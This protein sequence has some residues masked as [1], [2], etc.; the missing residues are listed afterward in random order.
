MAEFDLDILFVSFSDPK[1]D[2][3]T[4]NLVKLIAGKQ[5]KKV[6]LMAIGKEEDKRHYRAL[7]IQFFPIEESK[8]SKM[9][10][11]WNKFRT[12]A[13]M[14]YRLIRS[15]DYFACDLWSL[16]VAREMFRKA[17]MNDRYPHR[18]FYDSREIYSALGPISGK[19]IKQSIITEAEKVN[20]KDV[21]IMITSGVMDTD[22]LKDHFG[23]R[24]TP[25]YEIYN[26]PSFKSPLP[27][28]ILRDKLQL[29]QEH[30]VFIY[31]GV[32]LPGR[33]LKQAIDAV[34]LVDKAHLFIVGEGPYYSEIKEYADSKNIGNK[35]VFT[36]PVHYNRLHE[37]TCSAD[38]GLA[39]FEPVSKSYELSLPNKLFEYCMAGIPSLITD[40]PQMADIL[41]KDKIGIAVDRK[42]DVDEIADKMA[43]L[44]HLYNRDEFI[45]ATERASRRYSYEAQKKDILEIFR[46]D[47][48]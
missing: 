11:R 15:L 32:I 12:Q 23:N 46:E 41:K 29:T 17:Q 42:L 45:K 27:S 33:G 24:S 36:G 21:D 6:G 3:R 5:N 37:V 20:V 31:Q 16:P 25:Y 19:G 14:Y 35:V 34:A 18:L 30:S 43:Y 7:S 48:F 8:S 26:Y 28:N 9:T 10:L 1:K 47:D 22:Y 44:H 40:L 13:K 38:V 4:Y 39:L 2:G